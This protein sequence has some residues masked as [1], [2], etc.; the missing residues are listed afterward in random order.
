MAPLRGSGGAV[1][2]TWIYC[3]LW[4]FIQDACKVL[5]YLI[6]DKYL[7]PP[8]P[9]GTAASFRGMR[10]GGAEKEA[11]SPLSS[12]E[13]VEGWVP[14][15]PTPMRKASAALGK[16]LGIK[17]AGGP[18]S[19]SAAMLPGNRDRSGS[20]A[21]TTVVNPVRASAKPSAKAAAAAAGG[22]TAQRL[23]SSHL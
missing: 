20:R 5:T 19:S 12:Q 14:P 9:P 13:S 21:T 8:P 17:V 23:P 10:E 3:I 6:I 4:W 7:D 16:M 2:F 18:A 22:A 1:V 15:P 11:L